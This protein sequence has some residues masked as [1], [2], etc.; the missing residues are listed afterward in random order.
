MSQSKQG[1]V[2]TKMQQ[3]QVVEHSLTLQGR[4]TGAAQLRGCHHSLPFWHL[5]RPPAL[6]LKTYAQWV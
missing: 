2:V 3:L 1:L 5:A 4:T 6:N